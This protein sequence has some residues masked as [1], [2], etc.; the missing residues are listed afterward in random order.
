MQKKSYRVIIYTLI[1]IAFSTFM[2]NFIVAYGPVGKI[3]AGIGFGIIYMIIGD[4]L[5]FFRIEQTLL[6]KIAGGLILIS[7]YLYILTQLSGF[8][9]LGKGFIGSVD[10]II[11]T[12]PRILT[13]DTEALMILASAAI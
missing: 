5:R 4:V 9:T 1:F 11:F 7:G 10:F 8:L 6:W 2:P 12:L 13:L 3:L